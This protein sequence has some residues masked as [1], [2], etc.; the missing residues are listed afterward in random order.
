LTWW[1]NAVRWRGTAGEEGGSKVRTSSVDGLSLGL[2]GKIVAVLGMTL[3]TLG[4]FAPSPVLTQMA[5]AFA[6]QPHAALLTRS[7]VSVVGLVIAVSAPIFGALADRIGVRRVL[8]AALAIYAPAGCAPFFL[9][10]LYS[11][12]ATR[13]L[14]GLSVA[15]FGAVTFTLLVSQGEGAGRERWVS[16]STMTATVAGIVAYPLIGQVGRLGWRWPFLIYA[17]AAPLLVLALAGIRAD[18]RRTLVK[19]AEGT[20]EPAG[21][22][23]VGTPWTFIVLVLLA[24]SVM[25]SP[26]I[27]IPFRIREV[28][29][30]DSGLIGLLMM[31]A[32]V[33]AAVGGSVYGPVRSRLSVPATFAFGFLMMA[34]GLAISAAGHGPAAVVLGQAITSFG[35]GLNIPNLFILASLTGPDSS[36]AQTIG[37]TKSG[38][39]GGP[40]LGQ[41]ALEPVVAR[42]NV[43][44]AYALLGLA[45]LS[46]CIFYSFRSF[47]KNR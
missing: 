41:V 35:V 38:I 37:F 36:R 29:V 17:I 42:S 30:T 21:V 7:L 16:Y 10:D 12:L 23:A 46:F 8:L 32:S 20:G 39:F 4:L 19:C 44:A 3:S 1:A 47:V 27:F 43:A 40:M 13:I 22:V 25:N 34:T 14:L 18:P 28:G 5:A 15:A 33:A 31:P 6:S 2:A 26:S 45:C 11:I 24:G 9:N